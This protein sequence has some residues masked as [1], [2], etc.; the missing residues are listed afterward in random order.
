VELV[1]GD[2]TSGFTLCEEKNQCDI[3]SWPGYTYLG[4]ILVMYNAPW[5]VEFSGD[6]DVMIREQQLNM[7]GFLSGF[8]GCFGICCSILVLGLGLIFVFALKDPAAAGVL[9]Q[10]GA[11]GGA[12]VVGMHASPDMSPGQGPI[13]HTDGSV[14]G[15]AQPDVPQQQEGQYSQTYDPY[16]PPPGDGF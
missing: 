16:Q 8:A 6:G 2:E 12:Q 11:A 15:V 7:G 4:D 13:M 5:E 10:P 9:Y 14:T 1:G 3:Y